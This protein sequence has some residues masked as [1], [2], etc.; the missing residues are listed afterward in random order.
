MSSAKVHRLP[1]RA[2]RPSTLAMDPPLSQRIALVSGASRGIGLEVSKQLAA[3]GIT[4][5]MGM[6]EPSKGDKALKA[7]RELG[8]DAYSLKLDVTKPRDIN[9]AVAHIDGKFGRLDILINNAGGYFDHAG[10]AADGDLENIRGAL[11]VNLLGAWSLTAAALPIMRRHG[12]GRIVNISSECAVHAMCGEKAPAYRIS[13]AALNAYTQVV[14]RETQGSGILIN[15]VC[16][17]WTATDL[18]GAGGRPVAE[19]A[20]GVVWAALVNEHEAGTGDFYRDR[21]RI[22]W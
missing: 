11:D 16:P 4:V 2:K 20:E 5:F 22:A 21:A 3:L 13:K 9:A 19:S 6:R 7:V 12:Y 15:A 1:V 17:G 18:G 10:K 14:A 8:G